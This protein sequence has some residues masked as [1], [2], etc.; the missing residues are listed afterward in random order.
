ML[1]FAAGG[2]APVLGLV[3][4][5]HLAQCAVCRRRQGTWEVLAGVHLEA[6]APSDMEADALAQTLARLDAPGPAASTASEA[7][8]P[9]A[10]DL[11][12]GLVLPSVLARAHAGKRRWLAPG[13]WL[14]PIASDRKSDTHAY[15][16]GAAAGKKLPH[17][18]H[19]GIEMTCVLAGDFVDGAVRYGPGDFREVDEADG[20]RPI[21]GTDR[22]CVCVIGSQGLPRGFLG[23]MMRPFA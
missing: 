4:A 9:E 20:H 8:A 14:R 6:L 10:P 19:D 23:W 18:H 1:D 13:I 5:S 22:E 7:H 3:M 17:H 12:G 2:M 15:L 16:L 21:V 11:V